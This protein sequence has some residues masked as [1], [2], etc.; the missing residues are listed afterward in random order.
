MQSALLQKERKMNREGRI[1]RRKHRRYEAKK[2]AFAAVRPLCA[3]IGRII[4]ISRSGLAFHY[5]DT[6]SQERAS[7]ELDIFLIG[8]RFRLNRMPI[9]IISDIAMPERSSPGS[10]T[11]KRCGVQYGELSRE[12]M[13]EV[14]YF[15]QHYTLDVA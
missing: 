13:V 6:D 12:Q 9:R 10:L 1:E 14:G 5:V 15:I 4:D 3:K 7:H 8:N 2:G 11:M